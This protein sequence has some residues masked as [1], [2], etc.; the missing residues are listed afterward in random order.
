MT[1]AMS[2]KRAAARRPRIVE[3][4]GLALAAMGLES[5]FALLVDGEPARPEDVF[6]S[7]TAFVREPLMHRVGRS[8]HLPTGGAIYFDTGVIEVATPVIEIARGC[9]ARAGRSL[10]EGIRFVRGE[11]DAWEREHGRRVQLAGFSAHYNISFDVPA[12]ERRRGRSVEALALLLTYVLPFP[13]MVLAANRRSTGVGVRPRG[14]RVEVTVDFTPDPALMIAAATL[15]VGIVR[16]VMSW[17]RFT[18]DELAARGV[19]V[20]RDFHPVPHS[21]RQGWVA[22]FS[23]FAH[24]PFQCDLAAPLWVTRDGERLTMRTL[25]TGVARAFWPSIRRVADPFTLRLVAAVLSGRAPSLLDLHD[26]PEAY[27]DV[28]RL[29]RWDGALPSSRL[30]RSRY[31]RVLLH[32]IAGDRLRVRGE[33]WVPVGMR[34][35][36]HVVFRRERDRARRVWSLDDVLGRAERWEHPARQRPRRSGPRV[37]PMPLEIE[38]PIPLVEEGIAPLADVAEPVETPES[39]RDESSIDTIPSP[40]ARPAERN[41]GSTPG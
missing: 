13:V 19:P 34:G 6:G 33:R 10:W 27:G 38:R 17:R 22:K 24:N 9:A 11:L 3:R 21:S 20:L 2:K 37:A 26:R 35:W 25:A 4:R 40:A 1:T 31:E 15:I 41:S 8:Y 12:P 32:A 36:T 28:G 18:L 39:A 30:S 16:E 23:C 29:V 5:E 14:S 7:P